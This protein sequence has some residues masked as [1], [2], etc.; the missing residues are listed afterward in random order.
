MPPG[1]RMFVGV[2][3][4]FSFNR[5]ISSAINILNS[6]SKSI[7]FVSIEPPRSPLWLMKG[8][9]RQRGDAADRDNHLAIPATK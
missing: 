9:Q 4:K 5:S 7:A 1:P 3:V 8:R 6:R 2:V